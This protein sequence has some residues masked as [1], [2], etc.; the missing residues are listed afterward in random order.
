MENLNLEKLF[1]VTSP[2]DTG[3]LY[4]YFHTLFFFHEGLKWQCC[5]ISYNSCNNTL[6]ST[7][8]YTIL[9]QGKTLPVPGKDDRK[10]AENKYWELE[11]PF[12]C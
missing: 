4:T 2:F 6:D 10:I 3:T 9:L 12:T 11:K 5:E 8:C 7:L 1:D